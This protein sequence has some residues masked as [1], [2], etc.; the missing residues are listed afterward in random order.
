MDDIT[1]Q[2]GQLY[3]AMKALLEALN[4]LGQDFGQ[5]LRDENLGL[6]VAEEYSYSPN[7]LVLKKYHTWL[8]S[9]EDPA[10]PKSVRFAAMLVCFE[11]ASGGWKIGPR[12]RPELWFVAG[13][14]Q[15]LTTSLRTSM[16]TFFTA[17][18][19]VCYTPTPTLGGSISLYEWSRVENWKAVCIAYELGEIR[20]IMDLKQ[21]AVVPLLAEATRLGL[22]KSTECPEHAR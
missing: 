17:K 3:E 13:S 20:S 8:Y 9:Y 6:G 15:N 2:T 18:D 11:P 19:K 21:K 12:G 5:A 16:P 10:E 4:R 1:S 22:L 7:E 14:V